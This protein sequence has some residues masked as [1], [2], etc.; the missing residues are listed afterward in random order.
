[1]K[2]LLLLC[3]ALLPACTV[4]TGNR[5]TGQYSYRSVGGNASNFQQTADGMSGDINNADSFRE[6]NKTARFATGTI[7]LVGVAKNVTG[8]LQSVKNTS[9]AADVT[10]AAGVESTKQA[11]IAAEREAARMA[12]EAAAEEAGALV[13]P[14]TPYL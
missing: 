11:T 12:A 6:I 4:A 2:Q 10:K 3:L 9:T 13:L 14:P 7:G 1:M 5:N 8:A